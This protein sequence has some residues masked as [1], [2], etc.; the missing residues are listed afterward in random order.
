MVCLRSVMRVIYVYTCLIT[1]MVPKQQRL[2]EIIQQVGTKQE[3]SIEEEH[4]FYAL[5]LFTF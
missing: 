2:H 3:N 5:L 1:N 4:V